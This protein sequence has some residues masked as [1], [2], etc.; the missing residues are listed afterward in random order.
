MTSAW[1]SA[2]RLFGLVISTVAYG[3]VAVAQLTSFALPSFSA[4]PEP[5]LEEVGV[6]R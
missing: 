2:S 4:V 3:V 6:E 1:N 5:V